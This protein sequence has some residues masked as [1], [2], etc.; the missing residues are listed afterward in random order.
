MRQISNAMLG[1][2]LAESTRP[3]VCG[4]KQNCVQLKNKQNKKYDG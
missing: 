3:D 1:S 4:D 2:P